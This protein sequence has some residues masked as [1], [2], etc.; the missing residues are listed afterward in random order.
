MMLISHDDVRLSWPGAISMERASTYSRPWRIPFADRSLFHPELVSRAGTQAGIRLAFHSTTDVLK[1]R[2][3]PFEANQKLDLFVDGCF[4]ASW[5][6]EGQPAFEF[7]GL[8]TREKLIELWLPQRGDFALEQLEIDDLASLRPY[9]DTRPRW[10][11]YGSSITHC[12][13]SQSPS[14][15]WPSIV[16]R[17]RNWNLTCLGYGG[18]CHLDIE[19]ARMM[20]DRPADYIS[21]CAGINIYGRPS[22]NERTF[23]SSLIGFVRILREKHLRAPILLISPIYSR[24][25]E[26]TPNPQGWTLSHYRTAVEE[27][28]ALLREHGDANIHYLS[29]LKIAGPELHERMPDQLHPDSEGAEIMG[30][31]FLTHAAP[32]LAGER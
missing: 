31:N 1:G 19:I 6:L 7:K 28:V 20:R 14:L 3:S 29:G 24:P 30:R 12:G 27:A 5:D 21:I 9:E 4:V 15:T 11:T 17:E 18:Q 10:M 8:G 32:I 23:R 16:A 2:T 25:R 26:D 13:S 22:L